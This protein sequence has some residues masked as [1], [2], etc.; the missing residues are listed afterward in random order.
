MDWLADLTIWVQKL[1]PPLKVAASAVVMTVATFAVAVIWQSPPGAPA[2]QGTTGWPKTKSLE[3]LKYTLERTSDTNRR[4]LLA[5]LDAGW[6][7]MYSYK[8]AS[9][10]GLSD[11][12]V[13]YRAKD[14]ADSE[15]V[16]IVGQTA[17]NVRLHND[18]YAAIGPNGNDL[19][20]TLLK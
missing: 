18:V 1:A 9:T 6:N 14:L 3:A 5:V 11:G 10:V 8:L 17:T 20:R 19:L 15:L 13:F 4:L 2:A 16:E 12:E 7:G